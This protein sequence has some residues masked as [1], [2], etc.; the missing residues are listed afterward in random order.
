M[1]H[2]HIVHFDKLIQANAQSS[3][4]KWFMHMSY[5]VSKYEMYHQHT[6]L[7]C[8]IRCFATKLSFKSLLQ[9]LD[10][11]Q[12]DL[13]AIS[14]FILNPSMFIFYCPCFELSL[15]VCICSFL[16]KAIVTNGEWK[17]RVRSRNVVLIE[18]V[19]RKYLP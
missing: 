2:N 8:P 10:L 7:Y 14:I 19:L 11:K 3:E 12:L 18:S 9:I 15:M 16:G 4:T 13:G 5:L 1:C 6:S 17:K